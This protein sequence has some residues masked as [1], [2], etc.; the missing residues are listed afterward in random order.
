MISLPV[1]EVVSMLGSS[2]TL[3]AIRVQTGNLKLDDRASL[4]A[5]G[6]RRGCIIGYLMGEGWVH[7]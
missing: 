1:R 2:I 3:K 4:I 5:T 6:L 7:M